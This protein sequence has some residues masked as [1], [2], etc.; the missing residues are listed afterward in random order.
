VTTPQP[1]D[2]RR[3]ANLKALFPLWREQGL[4]FPHVQDPKSVLLLKQSPTPIGA[5]PGGLKQT[6]PPIGVK[7]GGLKQ[8]RPTI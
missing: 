5:K 6:R 8:N 3:K 2:T 1:C 7:P 4:C